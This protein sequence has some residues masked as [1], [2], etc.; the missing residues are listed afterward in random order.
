VA[1][2]LD[3]TTKGEYD[4]LTLASARAS[5]VVSALSGTVVVEV[6]DGLDVL[7]A[8]GTMAAPWATS[9]GATITVGEVTG[10]GMLVTSGGAPT[11]EWY[12]QFRSGSRFVRGT[13]GVAGS[14]RDFVWSL[15]SFQTGARGT[16]GT[17]VVLST[18]DPDAVAPVNTVVPSFTGT[19]QVGQSLSLN[20]G[21]WTNTPTNY[22]RQVQSASTVG[23][24]YT[25]ISGATGTTYTPVA[26]DQGRF[27][28]LAV[29]ASNAA[30]SGLVAYSA[31]TSAVAAAGI[32]TLLAN[33]VIEVQRSTTNE[34]IYQMVT[35]ASWTGDMPTFA[36]PGYAIYREF[37]WQA[38]GADIPGAIGAVYSP[39]RA[40]A[41]KS[42]RLKE[43]S[44]FVS[45]PGTVYTAYSNALT[46]PSTFASNIVYGDDLVWQGAF[47]LPST[48][49]TNP[50]AI[51][52]DST[53]NSGAGSLYVMGTAGGTVAGEVSIPTPS[54]ST[55]F[56]ALPT[57]TLLQS[58]S[59]VFNGVINTVGVSGGDAQIVQSIFPTDDGDLLLSLHNEYPGGG[60]TTAYFFRRSK[61]LASSTVP[62]GPFRVADGTRN[63][64]RTSNGYVGKVPAALQSTLGG[65][66]MHGLIP[67][68]GGF[69]PASS[70][71]P[72]L[73][74]MSLTDFATVSSKGFK[75]TATGGT[76][77]S[78][79]LPGTASSTTN[80]YVGCYIQTVPTGDNAGYANRVTAYNGT[81]KVATMA[82]AWTAP[83][84]GT[85][86]VISA[87]V[88]STPLA[89]YDS[90]PFGANSVGW[91]VFNRIFDTSVNIC[92][93]V[94][95]EGKKSALMFGRHGNGIF[96]YMSNDY[97]WMSATVDV[98][99]TAVTQVGSSYKITFADDTVKI[100]PDDPAPAA[101]LYPT[102]VQ[103]NNTFQVNHD[104][105]NPALQPYYC[106]IHTLDNLVVPNGQGAPV[107]GAGKLT[108]NYT[109]PF[110]AYDPAGTSTGEHSYPYHMKVWTYNTDDLAA[111]KSGSLALQSIRPS[112]MRCLSLPSAST[113]TSSV[114]AGAAYDSATS[115]IYVTV[116]NANGAEAA[117][118]VFGVA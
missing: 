106:T 102:L 62:S 15:A 5:A 71:G 24:T 108:R 18:G 50:G 61:T 10:L 78:V 75:F 111:V 77:T 22:T 56:S 94:I 25:N 67:N 53:G 17:V 115:R 1:I 55:T 97:N 13:F 107:V 81:T 63:A 103:G 93:V 28:R 35:P 112:Q 49:A 7:R 117:I 6:Y 12:C 104:S 100:N 90:L 11:A 32:S 34:T 105:V 46:A 43:R 116:T 76:S 110:F 2:L 16:L 88:N 79:T 96:K 59:D 69:F 109:W 57:A 113:T 19:V 84:N 3:T 9:S 66:L 70:C 23:G 73:N 83:T 87:P 40:D 54:T 37:V 31:A 44:W 51:G 38:D 86:M 36:A 20:V 48:L 58:T 98:T 30:G 33:P 118:H 92:G 39:A 89:N 14:G 91:N 72:S 68:S 82:D 64:P 101:Q 45:T 99:I 85:A 65:T 8:S 41:G 52:F 29:V 47:R 60:G 21:T 42:I 74:T 4:A 27:L 26:G 95:P 80:F 114:M